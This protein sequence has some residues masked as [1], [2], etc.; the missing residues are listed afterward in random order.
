MSLL[1]KCRSGILLFYVPVLLP[2]TN[3][4]L[5]HQLYYIPAE[6]VLVSGSW[7]I[8]GMQPVLLSSEEQSAYSGTLLSLVSVVYRASDAFELI[9]TLYAGPWA[10]QPWVG[11]AEEEEEEAGTFE[12]LASCLSCPPDRTSMRGSRSVYSCFCKQG[13][14]FDGVSCVPVTPCPE[15]YFIA[16]KETATR[17]RACLPCPSCQ[18][19]FYRDPKDCVSTSVREIG[20]PPVCLPCRQCPAGK[21]INPEACDPSKT[22]PNDPVSDCIACRTCPDM[23]NKVCVCVCVCKLFSFA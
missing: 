21:Y 5:V 9:F 12:P 18:P 19:G 1:S 8:R 16:A 3:G 4:G 14:F 7:W 13:T 10:R 11:A 23:Y 15:G 20:L 2:N 17:D 22:R 6:S